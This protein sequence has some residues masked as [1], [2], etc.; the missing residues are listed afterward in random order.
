MAS[1]MHQR[2][3]SECPWCDLPESSHCLAIWTPLGEAVS[4]EVLP[5]RQQHVDPPFLLAHLRLAAHLLLGQ[6]ACAKIAWLH[7]DVWIPTPR[8]ST[9][10]DKSLNAPSAMGLRRDG[11]WP[12]AVPLVAPDNRSPES[13]VPPVYFQVF[14]VSPGACGILELCVYLLSLPFRLALGSLRTRCV[15]PTPLHIW[16]AHPPHALPSM[17]PPDGSS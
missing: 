4:Q 10:S 17:T 6:E 2:H 3:S 16:K 13:T 11:R 5:L 9:H 7:I 12:P 8:G 14:I 1:C 15:H